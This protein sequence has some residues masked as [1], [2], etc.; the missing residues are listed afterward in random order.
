M[1]TVDFLCFL[2]Q[3]RKRELGPTTGTGNEERRTLKKSSNKWAFEPWGHSLTCPKEVWSFRPMTNNTEQ[4]T[5]RL[6]SDVFELKL[7]F[8]PA[9]AEKVP[10]IWTSHIRDTE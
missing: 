9:I 4:T 5:T 1:R 7:D 10:A 6:I 3:K 2:R 8:I